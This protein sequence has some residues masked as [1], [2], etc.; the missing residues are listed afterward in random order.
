MNPLPNLI[1]KN[2]NQ[3]Q[4]KSRTLNA[5]KKKQFIET[6]KI[7]DGI[8]IT[9]ENSLLK[10]KL[11]TIASFLSSNKITHV[12]N[13]AQEVPNL[14]EATPGLSYLSLPWKE[15]SGWQGTTS[16]VIL[17]DDAWRLGTSSCGTPL[18]CNH[19]SISWRRRFILIN[20]ESIRFCS[21]WCVA[22]LADESCFSLPTRP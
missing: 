1:L 17:T 7:T 16:L 20:R 4:S 3:K 5:P 18:V 9:S 11:A 13:A 12:I 22:I 14:F 21:R 2:M 8:F 19:R 15:M 10:D 6:I